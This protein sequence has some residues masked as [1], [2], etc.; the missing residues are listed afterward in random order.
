MAKYKEFDEILLKDGRTGAIVEVLGDGA[1]YLVDV[2]NSPKTWKTI[3]AT[4]DDIERLA[5]EEELEADQD[6]RP[7]EVKLREWGYDA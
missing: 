5:T 7:I 1:L 6:N 3:E 4:D 2:G